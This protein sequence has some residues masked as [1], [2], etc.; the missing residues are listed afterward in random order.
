MHTNDGTGTELNTWLRS[1]VGVSFR[2]KK[3]RKK[4]RT[5]NAQRRKKEILI[6]RD[7]AVNNKLRF[8]LSSL[9]SSYIIDQIENL[10]KCSYKINK[11]KR[12]WL[13]IEKDIKDLTF[14]VKKKKTKRQGYFNI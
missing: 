13:S 8:V 2:K 1:V 12:T 11:D 5:I 6:L 3:E 14:L 9:R 4:L 10:V 7:V